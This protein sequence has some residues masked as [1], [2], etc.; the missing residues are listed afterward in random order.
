MAKRKNR[1][2]SKADRLRKMINNQTPE[3]LEQQ[4]IQ[5]L[6][7]EHYKLA[8]QCLK[9]SVKQ[10]D[11]NLS[12]TTLHLFQQAYTGRAEELA[13]QGMVKEAIA[14]WEAAAQYGLDIADSRYIGWLIQTQ[15]HARLLTIY[16]KM[17]IEQQRDLYSHLAAALLSGE[18]RLLESL[19]NGDPVLKDYEAAR[20]LLESWCAGADKT[21]LQEQMK[22]IAFRSP[23]RDLRQVI[24]A[25]LLLETSPDKVE[26][27]LQRI[28]ADSP[29]Q[30]LVSQIH[31]YTLPVTELMT[32][33]PDMSQAEKTAVLAM[34]GWTDHA[35][36][37]KK[38]ESLHSGFTEK[39]LFS[40]LSGLY[41]GVNAG[42]HD[43][44]KRDASLFWLANAL[45]KLW[46]RV[47]AESDSMPNYRQ[48]ESILGKLSDIE[49]QRLEGLF[50]SASLA[51]TA[52]IFRVWQ[53]YREQLQSPGSEIAKAE[54]PLV[55][56]L[57]LRYLA[58]QWEK[59]QGKVTPR[60]IKLLEESLQD[61]PTAP[62]SWE[63]VIAYY[64]QHRKLKPA[65]DTLKQALDYY[66]DH[67]ALLEVGIRVAIAGGAFKKATTYAKQIL[68][69]DPI[70][71]RVQQHLQN[72]HIA[73]A[74]KVFK[75]GKFH[76]VHKELDA[77]QHWKGSELNKHVISVLQAFLS[78]AENG[79]Q[80]PSLLKSLVEQSDEPTL[81][82]F[83]I[84]H[85]AQAIGKGSQH[86]LIEAGL[87]D[88][89]R[90]G[91]LKRLKKENL[92]RLIDTAQQFY[93]VD[94]DSIEFP[95][96]ELYSPLSKAVKLKFSAEE[97]EK[98]CEFWLQTE[99]TDLLQ[100]YAKKLEKSWPD[101]PIFTY[102]R[103]ADIRS[104]D[105]QA[106]PLLEKAWE[107]ARDLGDTSSSVRI[108]GLLE[109]LVNPFSERHDVD[110]DDLGDGFFDFID[111][112]TGFDSFQPDMN[113]DMILSA[114]AD[115]IQ[116][117]PLSEVKEL[118]N[119]ILGKDGVAEILKI[120]GERDLRDLCESALR[121]ESPEE[122]LDKLARKL[123]K[124]T[125]F[126]GVF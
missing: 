60:S 66:P 17:P 25:W 64:L 111:A 110:D 4:A 100:V 112:P 116:D 2:Q 77:A 12:A 108:G 109:R 14:I 43:A 102:Y 72:A 45:K 95:L 124:P 44:E 70:N 89:W 36:M 87:V 63:K 18:T 34:R 13:K 101:K 58:G 90:S 107:K 69:V 85:E 104:Y 61:D 88:L 67:I 21:L 42:T 114:I 81:F 59:Y 82:D 62:G 20:T 78:R 7:A 122:V 65:R 15:N 24:Q 71:T 79:V 1:N 46:V 123:D 19:P 26:E 30:P 121:G 49:K 32:R 52:V 16:H 106:I 105:Y 55:S 86:L 68:T 94:A 103:Y 28:P 41:K 54:Q 125:P 92:L 98:I 117:M 33:L 51:P 120:F 126:R 93:D 40:V 6:S 29:F 48:L 96:Q 22:L 91:L 113:E 38:L 76:L 75:Q 9:S 99:Q 119:N 53:A 27:A 115:S 50:A 3:Q 73:H 83:I 8:I 118:A 10:A 80:S 39:K 84:R 5:A 23:Y 37:I 97:G 57:V 56:A 35:A 47:T 74:R 31:L 11:K